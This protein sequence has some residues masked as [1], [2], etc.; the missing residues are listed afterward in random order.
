M[1]SRYLSFKTSDL[2]SFGSMLTTFMILT[3]FLCA[4]EGRVKSLHLCPWGTVRGSHTH[5][6]KIKRGINPFHLFCIR[7]SL[8][9]VFMVILYISVI[10]EITKI[11]CHVLPRYYR[12]SSSTSFSRY[13]SNS[14]VFS[15]PICG[16]LLTTFPNLRNSWLKFLLF[17]A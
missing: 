5:F 12:N 17:S 10:L 15:P 1:V 6:S 8:W 7:G 2:F 9:Q 16:R 13:P 11:S 3:S 14:V 4:G